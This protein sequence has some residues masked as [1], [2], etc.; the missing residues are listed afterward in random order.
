MCMHVGEQADGLFVDAKGNLFS[1]VEMS[2][3][4]WARVGWAAVSRRSVLVGCWVVL[5]GW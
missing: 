3:G 4:R 2:T 1:T 5:G